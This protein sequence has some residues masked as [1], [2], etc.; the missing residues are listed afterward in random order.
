VNRTLKACSVAVLCSTV[1]VWMSGSIASATESTPSKDRSVAVSDLPRAK[2]DAEVFLTP[3]ATLRQ[4]ASARAR[5]LA[6]KLV[7]EVAY[8]SKRTAFKLARK[9]GL[10]VDRPGDLPVSFRV[11][12]RGAGTISEFVSDIKGID[13]LA[14]VSTAGRL[15]THEQCKPDHDLLIA[16]RVTATPAE[17]ET[18]RTALGQDSDVAT[19]VVITPDEAL[20]GYRC[21]IRPGIDL[22]AQP[23]DF[24]TFFSVLARAGSDLDALR[25]RLVGLRGVDSIQPPTSSASLSTR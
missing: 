18:V 9:R 6:S 3:S 25:A 20:A 19:S 4:I 1:T 7:V 22:V 13:G 10:P 12:L 14:N 17:I 24:P 5:L 2:T 15:S 16:M 23:A 8:L 21:M 11:K